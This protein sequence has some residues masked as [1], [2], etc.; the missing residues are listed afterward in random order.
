MVALHLLGELLVGGVIFISGYCHFMYYWNK[1]DFSW[2]RV[3]VVSWR[4]RTGVE[5]ARE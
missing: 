1:A 2:R 3:G 5:G 4:R